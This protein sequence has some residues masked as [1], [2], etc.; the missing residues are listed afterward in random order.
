MTQA[1][2]PVDPVS[3]FPVDFDLGFSMHNPVDPRFRKAKT[4]KRF[5]H[6]SPAHF[7][8][9]RSILII[10]PAFA[11]IPDEAIR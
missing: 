11:S 10:A 2:L 8:F 1:S 4:L 3:D 9:L 5:L 7:T 6:K